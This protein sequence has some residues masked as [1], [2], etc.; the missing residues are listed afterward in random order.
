MAIWAR[1]SDV[2]L[3]FWFNDIFLFLPQLLSQLGLNVDKVV[4]RAQW[5][6]AVVMIVMMITCIFG[7]HG[8]PLIINVLCGS[9][10]GIYVKQRRPKCGMRLKI[11]S[12]L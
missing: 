3:F 5:V 9:T 8:T 12:L 1:Y 4:L 2:M 10:W 7:Y 6:F 11:L